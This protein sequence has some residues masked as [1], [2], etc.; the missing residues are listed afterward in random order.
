MIVRHPRYADSLRH[1][2]EMPLPRR[3]VDHKPGRRN[4]A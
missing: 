3:T 2:V 4:G 1:G